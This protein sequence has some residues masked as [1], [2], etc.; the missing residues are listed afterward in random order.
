MNIAV[1]LDKQGVTCGIWQAATLGLF[2]PRNTGWQAIV[3][4]PLSVNRDMLPEDVR[5][6]VMAAARALPGC[7]HIVASEIT[8]AVK[9]WLDG[10]GFTMWQ[11]AGRPEGF[12]ERLNNQVMQRAPTVVSLPKSFI[13][14]GEKQGEF[15]ADLIAALYET[16]GHASRRILIPFLFK[17]Q[18]T[19]LEIT[20]DHLPRW[21][22]R[23]LEKLAYPWDV[24]TQSDGT[25][26]VVVSKAASRSQNVP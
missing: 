25:L 23:T 15:Q 21:F 22:S 5:H 1:F 11:C 12:L 6:Q 9:A 17:G 3:Q 20:C 26:R 8:G 2:A 4:V 18:F 24:T 10:M 16:E 19:R 14:P 13:Q 7:R